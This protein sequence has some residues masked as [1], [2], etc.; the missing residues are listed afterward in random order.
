MDD[1][2]LA[3]SA[4]GA[5]LRALPGLSAVHT[6]SDPGAF[7]SLCAREGVDLALVDLC[8]PR[9]TGFAVVS[10]LRRHAPQTRAVI[11]SGLVSHQDID[12][13]VA[14]GAWGYLY[15]ADAAAMIVDVIGRVARNEFVLSETARA[16]LLTAGEERTIAV[17][18]V[19]V[20]SK[21]AQIPTLMAK[22]E[23]PIPTDWAEQTPSIL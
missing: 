14:A 21:P 8:L 23:K 10:E 7:V 1:N 18:R 6:S 2:L 17:E 15:K 20:R 11:L 9:T 12:A 19:M 4:L 5:A 13:A 22:V 3:L 16:T